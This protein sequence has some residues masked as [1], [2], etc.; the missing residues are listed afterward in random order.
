MF[1]TFEGGEGC[2]KS[3]HA[4]E[5]KKYLAQRGEAAILTREPGATAI[6]KKIRQ[7]LLH[8]ERT[9]SKFTELFLFAADRAEHVAGVIL[10]A[11]KSG[12]IVICDR[13]TDSTSAYQIAGRKLSRPMVTYMNNVSSGGLKPDITFLLD[14]DPVKGIR[15]GTKHTGKDKFEAEQLSFHKRVR[16]EYLRIAK[17]DPGRVK[18]I[19]TDMPFSDVQEK[20]RRIVDEKLGD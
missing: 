9:V 2:G 13:F 4:K 14:I 6:G 5:L 11:L 19:R 12:K 20:I 18:F 7:M 15:R 3:T 17:S 16:K 8:S 1:I 10:P